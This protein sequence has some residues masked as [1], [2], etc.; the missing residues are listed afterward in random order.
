MLLINLCAETGRV[1]YHAGYHYAFKLPDKIL[2]AVLGTQV[3][4]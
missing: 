2:E 3:G 4:I 1:Y